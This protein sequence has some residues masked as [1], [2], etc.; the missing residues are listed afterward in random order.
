MAAPG[1]RI[2]EVAGRYRE[3]VAAAEPLLLGTWGPSSAPGTSHEKPHWTLAT[4]AAPEREALAQEPRRLGFPAPRAVTRQLLARRSLVG[5]LPGDT[6]GTVVASVWGELP[7]WQAPSR[8]VITVAP[9][10]LPTGKDAGSPGVG[11][12]Q[13]GL[14]GQQ[15]AG[16]AP[17]GGRRLAQRRFCYPLGI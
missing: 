8:P 10:S 3:R 14:A 16:L 5:F 4:P 17:P 1:P 15:P 12:R 11:N 6:E 7:A 9:A 2:Q 13:C